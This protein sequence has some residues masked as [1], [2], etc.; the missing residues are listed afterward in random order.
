MLVDQELVVGTVYGI[1]Q[2]SAVESD[3]DVLHRTKRPV[4]RER[5]TDL[6]G[7]GTANAFFLAAYRSLWPVRVSQRDSN[8]DTHSSLVGEN[9]EDSSVLG[10]EQ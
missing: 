1:V 8:G 3:L 2:H 6:A 9:P 4:Q 10:K 7:H 5:I